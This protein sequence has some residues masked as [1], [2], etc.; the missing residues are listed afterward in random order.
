MTCDLNYTYHISSCVIELNLQLYFNV[1]GLI[2]SKLFYIN[3]LKLILRTGK[4]HSC[5]KNCIIFFRESNFYLI[6]INRNNILA[7]DIKL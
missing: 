7:T 2:L 5:F 3:I 6:S 4:T 1:C